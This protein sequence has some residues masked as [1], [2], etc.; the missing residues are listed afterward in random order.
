MTTELLLNHLPENTVSYCYQ[1][2]IE[3]HFKFIVTKKRETKLGDYRYHYIQKTHT[4]TVNKDLNQYT[5]LVTYLHEV[6]HLTTQIKYGSKIKPHGQEWKNE[7]K[8]LLEPL[9]S[10]EFFPEKILDALKKYMTDPKASSCGDLNL[11]K[12]LSEY[13]GNT[14][15][16]FLSEINQG[17]TFRFNKKYFLKESIRRTRAICKDVKTGRK[18]FISEG[19]MVELLQKSLF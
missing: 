18:Y 8:I 16:T 11:L 3:N 9:M 7:F 12:A 5:F 15:M 2:W 1:L 14:H 6:A 10:R 19:A 4:I 13:D 17:E